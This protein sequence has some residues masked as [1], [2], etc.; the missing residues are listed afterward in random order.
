MSDMNQWDNDNNENNQM[1]TTTDPYTSESNADIYA[2]PDVSGRESAEES[3]S[4]DSP[5]QESVENIGT[6]DTKGLFSGSQTNTDPY[7]SQTNTDLYGSQPNNNPYGNQQN[8]NPYG[9]QMNSNPYGNQ[10]NNNPYG[11]QPNNI[12]YGNQ[13]DNSPYGNQPNSNPYGNQPNYNPYGNQN[14]NN[15]YGSQPN[16]NPYGSQQNN[17]SYGSQPVQNGN[18][19]Y[20]GQNNGGNYN[21]QYSPYAAPQKKSNTGLIIAIVVI[22]IILFLVAVFALAY[23]TID[24]LS[25][26]KHDVGY[27]QDDY[28]FDED[29]DYDDSDD[30][31]GDDDYNYDDS[32]YDDY[33]Y[34]DDEYYTLHDDIKSN[35]SYSVDFDYYEY[36]TD[37][38]NVSIMVSYP[39]IK[40]KNVPNL[41]KLNEVI[42]DETTF[43]KDYF[44][45]EYEQYIQDNEDS[46]FD[47][48]V[49][50]YVTYMDEEKLSIVFSESVYSDY[51][52]HVYLYCIN[53]DMENGVV[54]DNEDMLSIDDDFSVDFRTRSDEQNG[55]IYYLTSMTDQ[56]ITEYFNSPDII[57]FYTPQGMEIGFNYEEGWVTVTYDEYEQYL[58]VF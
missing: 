30:S 49:S 41:D 10:P 29:Y 2:T 21:N 16:N 53:I 57:V 34:D 51:Y 14:N 50:G 22:I 54:L 1:N 45:E 39:V 20:S 43:F 8:Y 19:Y 35:L 6:V 38:E 28:N 31:F 52:D 15:P 40:G 12:S 27:N 56:Q 37:Y 47:A 5:V 24:L 36:D 33:N 25:E 9:N 42:Q 46:Y 32:Y 7:G 26:Q 13:T 18:T 48:Y 11:N 17:Y 4:V 55:E 23:K 44:E 58:K 3:M